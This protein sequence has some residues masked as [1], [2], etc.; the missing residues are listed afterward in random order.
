MTDAPE[1]EDAYHPQRILHSGN[2]PKGWS[3]EFRFAPYIRADIAA[4]READLRAERDAALARERA[5]FRKLQRL[6]DRAKG[7]DPDDYDD[8]PRCRDCADEDGRCPHTGLSCDPQE[9]AEERIVRVRAE[10]ERLQAANR[11]A[12]MQSLADLWQAQEALDRAIAAEAEVERLSA[13]LIGEFDNVRLVRFE[14]GQF[15]FSGGPV[16][17]IAEYFAQMFESGEGEYFNHMEIS[18]SHPKAGPM[19]LSVQRRNG[20]TPNEQRKA[21]QAEAAQLRALLDDAR[22]AMAPLQDMEAWTENAE[23]D[24]IVI[25]R[26]S[27]VK[28]IRATLAKIG[29]RHD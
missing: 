21:A 8:G 16:R 27:T 4:A 28:A 18:F 1:W 25:V 2:A 29:G 7:Y 10:V 23:P 26:H 22:A 9:A 13:V 14:N 19:V 3:D 15:D 17:Y 12:A 24:E 6:W 20:M 5:I 11:E